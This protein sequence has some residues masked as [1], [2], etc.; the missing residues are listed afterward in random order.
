MTRNNTEDFFKDIGENLAN[1]FYGI[2]QIAELSKSIDFELLGSLPTSDSM[3][4]GDKKELK[5]ILDNFCQN[6]CLSQIFVPFEGVDAK[7]QIDFPT[8]V[9]SENVSD[10]YNILAE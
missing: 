7:Y 8:N 9:R 6:H 5:S 1:G 10:I 4:V 3:S 2:A